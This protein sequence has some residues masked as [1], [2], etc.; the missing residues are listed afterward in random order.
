MTIEFGTDDDLDGQDGGTLRKKLEDAL[1]VNKRQ[2]TELSTYKAKEFLVEKG[3]DLVK[4]E[5]LNGVAP[6]KFEEHA[7]KV[8]QDRLAQQQE[9]LRDALVKRG[10]EGE[11]LEEALAEVVSDNTKATAE[12]DA[13]RRIRAAGSAQAAPIPRVD[14]SKLTGFDAIR[15][16]VEKNAKQRTRS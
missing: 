14:T 2:S 12:A 13:T 1:A 16:G 5:D 3:L 9:L 10:Y 7:T 4:A 8:Q 11:D 6:D 15:A